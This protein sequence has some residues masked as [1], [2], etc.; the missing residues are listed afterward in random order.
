M[1][2]SSVYRSLLS[3]GFSNFLLRSHKDLDLINQEAVWDFLDRNRPD[4]VFICAAVV[5]GIYANAT[6]P[7]KFLY[8]NLQIQNNLIHGSYKNNVKKL[9]FVASSCIYPVGFKSSISEDDILSG[10][11]EK[12]NEGYALAKVA[13]IKMCQFYKKQY[14]SDFISVIPCNLYGLNDNYH[15]ESAHMVP[16]MI[17]KLHKAKVNNKSYVEIWGTGKPK[18]EFM[19]SDDCSDAMLFL[20]ENYKDLDIINIGLGYDMPITEIARVIRDVV[21]VDVE[22]NYNINFPD[23]IYRKLLNTSK[24][25]STGWKV[26]HSFKDGIKIAYADFLVKFERGDYEY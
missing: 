20:M 24:L 5:G 6:H 9:I 7:G 23:G 10:P 15:L 1:I 25:E 3:N 16:A 22:F 26:K 13:G 21:D 18:R 14:G 19:L 17:H 2:K 8:E 11:F 12:T 4:Y